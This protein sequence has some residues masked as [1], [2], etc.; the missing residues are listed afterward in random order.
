MQYIS[1]TI[2]LVL[3]DEILGSA[4]QQAVFAFDTERVG[5]KI[6]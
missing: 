2:H 6:T 1:M 5:I 4:S 3:T